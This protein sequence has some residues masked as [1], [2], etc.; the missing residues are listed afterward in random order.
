MVTMET[1]L[2]YENFKSCTMIIFYRITHYKS[3]DQGWL[4]PQKSHDRKYY[5]LPCDIASYRDNFM[6]LSCHCSQKVSFD[7]GLTV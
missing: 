4:L 2:T 3:Y 1:K 7:V 5:R 6:F